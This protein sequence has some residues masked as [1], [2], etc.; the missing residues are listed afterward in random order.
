MNRSYVLLTV[1]AGLYLN[2]L[3][4]MAHEF[5][6]DNLAFASIK[7]NPEFDIDA[8]V[9][10]YIE[11]YRPDVWKKYRNDEFLFREKWE[12][13]RELL[14]QRIAQFNLEETFVIRGNLRIG[15]YNF[16]SQEFPLE[17]NGSQSYWYE[18]SYKYSDVLPSTMKVYFTNHEFMRALRLDRN[19]AKNLVTSR[20]DAYGNI[21]RAIYAN[22][23]MRI[24]KLEA[25]GELKAEA[26]SVTYYSDS[27]RTRPLGPKL[28]WTRPKTEEDKPL[29]SG[30]S[31]DSLS[32]DNDGGVVANP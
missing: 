29:A 16:E 17:P 15:E 22:I 30:I 20:K 21:D 14:R 13:S 31:G 32:A 7:L 10:W 5:T 9:D 12:E 19:S 27:A 1:V 4:A 2:T 28:V 8:N 3:S 6:W 11:E 23:E 25:A 18:S 26:L 24:V